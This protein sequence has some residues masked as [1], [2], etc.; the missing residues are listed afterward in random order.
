MTEA[1]IQ[2]KIDYYSQ[3]IDAVLLAGEEY[4]NQSSGS[5]R[6]TKMP[7]LDKLEKALAY[8]EMRLRDLNGTGAVMT[9]F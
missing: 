9:Q 2:N 8:W 6:R 4:E 1:D 7:D 3:A 5:R